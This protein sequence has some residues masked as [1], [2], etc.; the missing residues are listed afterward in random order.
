MRSILNSNAF[1]VCVMYLIF[2]K[3][4][5]KYLIIFNRKYILIM[6]Q[7]NFLYDIR[8]LRMLEAKELES[9]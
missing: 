4:Y 9:L 3:S 5:I 7:V 1:V 6:L 8:I 2:N